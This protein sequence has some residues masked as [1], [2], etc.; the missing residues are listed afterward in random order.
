M[1][2]PC[3]VTL[4][5]AWKLFTEECCERRRRPEHILFPAAFWEELFSAWE[6]SPEP[7]PP[8]KCWSLFDL[9][10]VLVMERM[11]GDLGLHSSLPFEWSLK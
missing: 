4:A 6:F 2:P 7:P 10:R 1:P 11:A 5:V 3:K 8:H 9:F